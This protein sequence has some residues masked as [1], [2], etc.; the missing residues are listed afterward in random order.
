MS[1]ISALKDGMSVLAQHDD[2]QW[3]IEQALIKLTPDRLKIAIKNN[4]N[5]IINLFL[6]NKFYMNFPGI[7]RRSRAILDANWDRVESYL[8]NPANARE[9]LETIPGNTEI[10]ETDQGIEYL[11]NMCHD[12]YNWIREFVYH[13]ER[14]LV[15]ILR[16]TPTMP[17][18]D[19]KEISNHYQIS[20]ER[21]TQIINNL[22]ANGAIEIYINLNKKF[23]KKP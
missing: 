13:E 23:R 10:I 21:F 18:M 6:D 7:R 14:D 8:L 20:E 3:W 22:Q 1:K 11:N 4:E 15:D 2:P 19:F 12:A 9:L 17:L 5:A 16:E